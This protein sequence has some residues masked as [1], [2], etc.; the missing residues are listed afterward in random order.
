M[1]HGA[2]VPPLPGHRRGDVVGVAVEPAPASAYDR[3]V[4]PAGT[5]IGGKYRVERTLGVGGMG[6]VVAATHVQLGSE[7]ALKLLHPDMAR[8]PKI[9]ER[10]V[11]E[12]QAVAR[13][14]SDH[15]CRVSDV[16]TLADGVPF[17]VMELLHGQDLASMVRTTGAM[18]AS[19]VAEYV[20]QAA[21]G[22]AEAHAN[23]LVHRDLKPGNLFVV[24]RPSGRPL[25]KVLDFGIAKSTGANPDFSVTQTTSMMGSPGYMSPEQARSSKDV[26][27]R[28]DIWALG[29]V[30]YELITGR[31]PFLGESIT[32]LALKV[33]TEPHPPLPAGLPRA[34]V[35]IVDRCLEK[36]P[37]RRFPDVAALA[38]ALAP[39]VAG[40]QEAA[41]GVART[42]HG[43]GVDLPTGQLVIG[44]PTTLRSASGIA[45]AAPRRSRA[46]AIVAGAVAGAVIIGG[47]LI[48][49]SGDRERA[50]PAAAPVA[51]PAAAPV[52]A[53]VPAPAPAP[54]PAPT[55][56]PT[57]VPVPAPA[58]VAASVS[59][60]AGV[61][62]AA[63]VTAPARATPAAGTRR[64]PPA[65][66]PTSV[67]DL[68]DLRK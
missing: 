44:T 58:P 18:P 20:L 43:A 40:G 8:H 56:A 21:Q 54:A 11:R 34:F 7:V 3:A 14:H 64:R 45:E 16:G 1:P 22:L 27:A 52:A 46:G 30:M 55:P 13:L 12:A 35:E 38:H 60:D 57:P 6:V 37:A 50:A 26:D 66:P 15:L 41:V 33:V 10:F 32:E 67:E 31:A 63:P 42:L 19:T 2:R 47:A 59:V 25:V 49:L 62:V 28:A 23:G 53:P 4:Y 17:I 68:S 5:V 29:V 36:E 39:F 65:R 9:V 61:E 51:V 24:R 48:A